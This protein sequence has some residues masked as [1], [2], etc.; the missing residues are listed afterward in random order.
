VV[1]VNPVAPRLVP[2]LS[3]LL[4]AGALGAC[5]PAYRASAAP[6]ATAWASTTPTA[7]PT[8]C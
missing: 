4:L 3:L 7:G 1:A 5:G 8:R 2:A 6:G